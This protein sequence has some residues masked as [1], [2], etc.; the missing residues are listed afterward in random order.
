MKQQVDKKVLHL[1]LSLHLDNTDNLKNAIVTKEI[2][3][4]KQNLQSISNNKRNKKTKKTLSTL[5]PKKQNEFQLPIDN[6]TLSSPVK[7]PSTTASPMRQSANKGI[8]RRGGMG[9]AA[10]YNQQRPT[11]KLFIV[12][13]YKLLPFTLFLIIIRPL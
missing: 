3:Y 7:R 12:F 9:R 4:T 13:G 6:T 1:K 2:H 8:R 11:F 5:S 10:I